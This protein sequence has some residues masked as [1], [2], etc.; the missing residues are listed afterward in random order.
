MKL[1]FPLPQFSGPFLV[2]LLNVLLVS[3]LAM[4]LAY[5]SWQLWLLS[6]SPEDRLA[7]TA[8]EKVLMPAY[9][10]S[11]SDLKTRWFDAAADTQVAT[12]SRGKIRLVGVFAASD[13][14]P[15]HAIIIANG[16][17]AQTLT[18]GAQLASGE[19]IEKIHSDHVILQHDGVSERL[20]MDRKAVVQGLILPVQKT[21]R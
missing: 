15:S 9:Q 18:E 10:A 4:F 11:A 16:A 12:K 5:W 6:T 17:T 19:K 1:R 14:H 20:D 7:E 21:P 3:L 2:H 13:G 8:A